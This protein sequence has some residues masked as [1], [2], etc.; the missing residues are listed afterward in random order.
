MLIDKWTKCILCVCVSIQLRAQ[1]RTKSSFGDWCA[2]ALP[3]IVQY[4][5]V[6]FSQ[7][8]VWLKIQR[9]VDDHLRSWCAVSG[10]PDLIN[11]VFV[12]LLSCC[13]HCRCLLLAI[14]TQWFTK[15][16]WIERVRAIKLNC[17]LKFHFNIMLN[18]TSSSYIQRKIPAENRICLSKRPNSSW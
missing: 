6:K 1:C 10:S 14:L 3:P 12:S 8:I 15:Q 9:L 5:H 2:H 16:R 11:S 13:F 7:E 18:A 17:L 4:F